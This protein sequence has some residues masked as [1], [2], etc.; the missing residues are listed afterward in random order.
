MPPRRSACLCRKASCR[1]PFRHAGVVPKNRPHLRQGYR[2]P[3]NLFGEQVGGSSAD[4]RNPPKHDRIIA[5]EDSI[6]SYAFLH[7]QGRGFLRRRMKG[8]G[9]FLIFRSIKKE[10]GPK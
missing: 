6:R 8:E 2:L 9:F 1:E 7:C 3:K 4:Q 5:Y 10:G